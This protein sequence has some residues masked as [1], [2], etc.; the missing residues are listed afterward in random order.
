MM[1]FLV[2]NVGFTITIFVPNYMFFRKI[3]ILTDKLLISLLK[4]PVRKVFSK[5]SDHIRRPEFETEVSDINNR[6]L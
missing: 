3:K 4:Y 5:D 1:W 2:Y 6:L